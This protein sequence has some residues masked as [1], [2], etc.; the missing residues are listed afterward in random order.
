TQ[1]AVGDFQISSRVGI[2]RKSVDDFLQSI[3]D[4]RLFSQLK[5]LSTHFS[6]PILIIEGDDLYGRR[7]I[8]PNAIKGA[9]NSIA[10]DFRIP[11]LWTKTLDD[12]AETIIEIAKR[13]QEEG[14]TFAIRGARSTLSED[15]ELEYF[16]AGLPDVNTSF[17]KKLLEKF[18]TIKK[19]VNAKQE[20]LMKVEGI[21]EVRARKIKKLFEREYTKK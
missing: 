17:A 5:D 20:R 13:E 3:I 2:E 1:L 15:E 4:G 18:S 7:Q 10:V 21:G 9:L 8:H 11:I 19:L 6:R 16:V 12:T 14:K